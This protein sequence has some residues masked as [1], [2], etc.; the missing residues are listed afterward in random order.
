[1]Q[2]SY[3]PDI[4]WCTSSLSNIPSLRLATT[5]AAVKRLVSPLDNDTWDTTLLLLTYTVCRDHSSEENSQAGKSEPHAIAYQV[6]VGARFGQ[7]DEKC[8]LKPSSP[9]AL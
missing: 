5:A 3:I 7:M 2:P 9:S 4:F 8:A 1:M 6:G